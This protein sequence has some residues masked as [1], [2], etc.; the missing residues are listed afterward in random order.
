M[1]LG[2]RSL[3]TAAL[4]AA[5]VA[6]LAL[7]SGIAQA[8]SGADGAWEEILR[9]KGVSKNATYNRRVERVTERLLEAADQNPREWQIAVIEDDTPNAFALPGGQIG[10][11]SGLFKIT[12][13]DDELAA[14]IGHE[15]AHVTQE[16]G[17][18][19][20]QRGA[21][22][23][24]G[25]G[26][27]GAALDVDQNVARAAGMAATLGLVLPFSREQ[28]AQAD[29]VG[30]RYMAR[31]GY[32]PRAAV[33]V[34]RKFEE[35]GEGPPEFLATHPS[36]GNRA[37]QLEAMVP[38]VMETYRQRSKTQTRSADEREWRLNLD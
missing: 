11:H 30:L 23:E 29:D 9:E 31:A 10:V 19:R 8:Q 32:D 16:H 7:N 27:L 24:I 28:E 18:Q 26:I 33:R 3:R 34:W 21:L 22:L 25:L 20:M 6:P 4:A 13:T 36:S 35:Q 2:L 37:A 5:L 15:I 12:K 1:I 17:R 14:V 38:E